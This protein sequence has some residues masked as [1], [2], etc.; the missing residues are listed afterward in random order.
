MEKTSLKHKLCLGIIAG[1]VTGATFRRLGSKYLIDYLP[2]DVVYLF[3]YAILLAGLGMAFVWHYRQVDDRQH[4]AYGVVLAQLIATVVAVDLI[5]FGMQKLLG[6]QMIVP[7]GLLD[8]PF[9]SFSGE[10]LVWAFFRYS[11]G[12]TVVVAVLQVTAALLL[13]YPRTRLYGCL[14][15]LPIMGFILLMD[16][17]YDMP[18]GVL[19]HGII[20]SVAILYF[21]SHHLERLFAALWLGEVPVKLSGLWSWMLAL[22]AVPVFC[23]LHLRHPDRHPGLTGKYVVTGLKIDGIARQARS[24]TDSVLTTVYF[25]LDD[26]VVFRWN[27]YRR[28]RV[29]SYSLGRDGAIDMR[30]RYPSSGTA[31]FEGNLEALGDG[32]RLNG[33]MGQQHY[34]MRLERSR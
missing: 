17:C 10:N 2:V 31:A 9:S 33:L 8:T 16:F 27:D 21:L 24:D 6:L 1:L 25:D 15:A 28:Q 4:S 30:W 18:F 7:L 14:V 3:A 22:L 34:E 26:E 23:M 13:F 20:L 5:M 29:G 11:Y 19:L 12:F 32:W